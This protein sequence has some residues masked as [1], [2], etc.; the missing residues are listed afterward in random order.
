MRRSVVFVKGIPTDV[1][2]FHHAQLGSKSLPAQKLKYVVIPGN[3]GVIDYYIPFMRKLFEFA[4]THNDWDISVV[5]I[6]HAGHSRLVKEGRAFGRKPAELFTL[7]QQIDHKVNFVLA[8]ADL[9]QASTKLILVGHSVGAHICL[10]MLKGIPGEKVS[11]TILLFPTV[12]NIAQSKN[13]L[14]L[15]PVFRYFRPVASFFVAFVAQ[16]MPTTL[17]RWLIRAHFSRSFQEKVPH[18]HHALDA[19]LSLFDSSAVDNFFF[20]AHDE[21]KSIQQ[22][23]RDFV[24]DHMH[25]LIFYFAE[26]DGWVPEKV[27]RDFLHLF[28]QSQIIF[29][30]DGF[31]HA[32]VLQHGPEM[33]QKVWSWF[34]S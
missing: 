5:G 13:G 33:A 2:S 1:V 31:K 14:L 18:D 22:I 19:T 25:K 32:F 30:Q 8:D 12:H 34:I 29:C 24:M 7:R 4:S 20:M 23:D 26:F 10:E 3:P 16:F 28:P 15:S 11:Q 27:P 17:L 9:Q 6:S 21:M